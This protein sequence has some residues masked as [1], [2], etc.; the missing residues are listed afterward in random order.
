M[1]EERE[2]ARGQDLHS[3]V[4][5]GKGLDSRAADPSPARKLHSVEEGILAACRAEEEVAAV[6]VQGVPWVAG[7][8]GAREAC[9]CSVAFAAW[10]AADL[11]DT[12][13]ADFG[14]EGAE[15]A[16]LG[17]AVALEASAP[18]GT[19]PMGSRWE[20]TDRAETSGG[21]GLAWEVEAEGTVPGRNRAGSRAEGR[22]VRR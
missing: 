14:T 13:R 12:G 19:V 4:A 11:S 17:T 5:P 6:A 1:R 18:R 7:V 3:S 21:T 20:G 22:R 10:G 16:A 9:G 8:P 15:E 2:P